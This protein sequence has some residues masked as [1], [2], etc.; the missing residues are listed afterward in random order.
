MYDTTIWKKDKM[1]LAV[2][3]TA[4]IKLNRFLSFRP[5]IGYIQR[6]FKENVII[7]FADST[8]GVSTGID[9]EE[10]ATI[11]NLSIDLSIIIYPFDIKLKPYLLVGMRNDYLLWY[12]DQFDFQG[13][14]Y[15][16]SN[17]IIKDFNKFILSGLICLGFNYKELVYIELEYNPA[18]TN[19]FDN[20]N[21]RI[22]ERYFGINAGLYI[23]RFL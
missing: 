5:E 1:G 17:S 12:K 7:T 6:G 11:H 14:K 13:K 19:N 3:T 9:S 18:I 8:G 15:D 23:N 20:S 4:E 2:Y 21:L 10:K 16:I 22:K